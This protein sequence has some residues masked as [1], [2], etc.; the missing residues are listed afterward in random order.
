MN[1]KKSNEQIVATEE[2]INKCFISMSQNCLE[3]MPYETYFGTAIARALLLMFIPLYIYFTYVI[4]SNGNLDLIGS[5]LPFATF[6]LLLFGIEYMYTSQITKMSNIVFNRKTNKCYTYHRGITYINN[7]DDVIISGGAKTI[8]SVHHRNA[9]GISITRHIEID[10]EWNVKL[11]I[12]YIKSFTSQGPNNL[13][14]PTEYEWAD[15]EKINIAF[16]PLKA[17]I[18][19]APWPFCGKITDP[20]EKALKI[21]MWPFYVL[22]YFPLNIMASF[23]WYPFTKI[24][25]IKPHPVPEEAYEGD[26]SIR[27]TPEMAAKGI[28]P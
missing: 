19:Y 14:I 7:L 2:T 21:Y 23:L 9:N 11:I 10:D 25:N 4:F 20:L 22:I 17:L 8:I 12:D 5:Y 24:F 6:S 1:N 16:S 13:I 26:D 15:R 3:L 28:R 27:V 18:H